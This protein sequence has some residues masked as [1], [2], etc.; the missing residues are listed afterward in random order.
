MPH[1]TVGKP[2][3]TV[4][5]FAFPDAE[6]GTLQPTSNAKILMDKNVFMVLLLMMNN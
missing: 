6:P 4:D 3:F 1:W 2:I 5:T